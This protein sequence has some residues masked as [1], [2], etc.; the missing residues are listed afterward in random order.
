[1]RES[2][3]FEALIASAITLISSIGLVLRQK[4]CINLILDVV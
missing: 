3:I 1:M 2:Q 4:G